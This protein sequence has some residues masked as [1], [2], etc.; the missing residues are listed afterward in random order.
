[1]VT[2]A[3]AS[4][5]DAGRDLLQRLRA[6]H[7]AVTLVWADGG[8][9]GWLVA[10]AS[11]VLA[12]TLTIVKRPD[13]VSG[14]HQDAGGVPHVLHPSRETAHPQ[15]SCSPRQEVRCRNDPAFLPSTWGFTE[16]RTE[17]ISRIA[18]TVRR[19]LNWNSGL[20]SAGGRPAPP[21]PPAGSTAPHP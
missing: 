5:R 3:S 12:I 8:Y 14:H 1:M 15:P 19:Q 18:I 6:R 11:T 4:D 20:P 13:D 21:P 17:P 10:F 16:L 7:R 2:A 9:T